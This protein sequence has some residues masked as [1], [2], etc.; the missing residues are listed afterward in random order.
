MKANMHGYVST[1]VD[2]HMLLLL[3]SNLDF[4]LDLQ[5]RDALHGSI[6]MLVC[7][8]SWNGCFGN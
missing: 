6:M 1:Y 5:I 7:I 4:L 2:I 8:L 3:C